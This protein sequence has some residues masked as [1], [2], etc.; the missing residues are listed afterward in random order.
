MAVSLL[1][2]S[3]FNFLG[4]NVDPN[5]KNEALMG[6]IVNSSI[7]Q[8]KN[9]YGVYPVGR[10]GGETDGKARM[11]FVAFNL[12]KKLTKDEARILIVEIVELFLHNINQNT[13]ISSHLYNNPFTYKNLE[14]VVYILDSDRSDLYHPD[15]GLVSLTP[16]GTVSYVTYEPGTRCG[17]ASDVEETYEEAYRIATKN[18]RS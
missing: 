6:S 2:A 18:V 11:E 15:I 13:E 5:K 9:R 10:G 1:F 16:R 4:G 12:D 8:L 3:L 7:K 17:Y 14:F